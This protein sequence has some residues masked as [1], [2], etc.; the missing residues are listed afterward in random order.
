MKDQNSEE[1]NAYIQFYNEIKKIILPLTFVEFQ[2]KLKKCY[3]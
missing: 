2:E 1:I 3:K